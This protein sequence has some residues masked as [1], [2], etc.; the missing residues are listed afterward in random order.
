MKYLISVLLLVASSLF[1]YAQEVVIFQSNMRSKAANRMYEEEFRTVGSYK[2]KGNSYL[3]KGKNVSDIFTTLGYGANMGVVY[4]TYSQQFGVI[5]PDGASVINLSLEEVDSFYFK[6]DKE[7]HFKG[8]AMF[9]NVSRFDASQNKYMQELVNG[10][11]YKVY[12]HYYAELE[13]ASGNIAQ[14]DLKQFEIKSDYYFIDYTARGE[15]VL[16]KIKPNLKGLK[17]YFKSSSSLNILDQSGILTTEEK[18]ISF[19]DSLNS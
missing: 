8:P 5:Q 15:K 18:L 2:V 14:S 6:I 11:K 13:N 16:V 7:G 17:A 12:K 3:F 10:P 19:F 9:R 4:D 1:G